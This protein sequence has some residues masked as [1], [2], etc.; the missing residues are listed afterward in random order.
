MTQNWLSFANPSLESRIGMI[1][2]G[3]RSPIGETLDEGKGVEYRALP[4]KTAIGKCSNPAMPFEHTVNPY[5]GCEFAC[6]YCYAR[7]THEFLDLKDPLAFERLIYAKTG[8]PD[9]AARDLARHDFTGEPIAIGTATD[10]YQ[11]AERKFLVTRGILEKI[12]L[13]R[14]LDV[15][16]TTKSTLVLRDLDV[17]RKISERSRITVN[18]S[19]IT[20]DSALAR[21]LE[22]R[23]PS[24]DLR[25]KTLA[26][27]REAGVEAG[28]FAMPILPGL[29][30]APGALRALVRRAKEANALWVKGGALFLPS[31][32]RQVFYPFLEKEFP[33]LLRRYR[34]VFDRALRNSDDYRARLRG[35]IDDLCRAEGVPVDRRPYGA[36]GGGEAISVQREFSLGVAAAPAVAG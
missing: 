15:S 22:P 11:P 35:F 21:K 8:A 18:V 16:I 20:L 33:G 10:P 34:I 27:L 9:A 36:R 23:A 4:C 14:G 28:L 7:Y 25:L 2:T 12:A 5:R 17:I 31:A 13:R 30:D 32:A 26:R 24:P 3:P 1:P 29:T 6:R 19:L